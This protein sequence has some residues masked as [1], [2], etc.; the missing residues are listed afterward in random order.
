MDENRE[1]I[2]FEN[3][4]RLVLDPMP[5]LQTASVGV[6]VGAG[7]RHET[8]ELNGLAHF[9]E[10]MSFKGAG[11]LSARELA[12]TVE[13][14]GAVM[15]AATDYERTGFYIRCL[16]SDVVQMGGLAADLALSPELPEDEL[17][18]EKSVV[19]QEI[20][21]AN[22]APDDL[23]FELAQQTAWRGSSLGRPI[24]GTTTSVNGFKI[25][26]LTNF[27]NRHYTA[28]RVVMSVAGQFDRDAIVDLARAKL[29]S[30]STGEGCTTST[31]AFMGGVQLADRD[32]EQAHIVLSRE[33]PSGSSSDRFAA[34]LFTE[35][36]GGGM[37]SRLY[38]EVREARG[39]AYAIDAY[40]EQYSDTGRFDVYCGCSPEDAADVQAIVTDIWAD[41]AANGVTE[42][43]LS[44]AKAVLSAQLAMSSE[45]PA[46]RASSGAYELMQFN[47]LISLQETLANILS[48]DL[49]AIKATAQKA[50]SGPLV[51]ACVGPKESCDVVQCFASK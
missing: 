32:L 17:A 42:T 12:E 51:A 44:R 16:S 48:V 45:A 25:K 8:A 10:H 34:R 43:E 27:T 18:L 41:I 6:W 33:G 49:G 14:R 35:I 13:N 40:C 11:G 20:G 50:V 2:Q 26:D 4:A 47:R 30:L 19:L 28:E 5:H 23:V 31:P 22:D 36:F 38:Q 46:A 29:A 1:V 9:L 15:N 37:A 39:L 7:A 3:G 21:E 24:L